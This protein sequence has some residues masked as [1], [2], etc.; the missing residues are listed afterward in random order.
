MRVSRARETSAS[1]LVATRRV[2]AVHRHYLY[3][4]NSN[5]QY[6]VQNWFLYEGSASIDVTAD[7]SSPTRRPARLRA[8][9]EAAPAGAARTL[10]RAA[11]SPS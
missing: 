2:L 8:A 10:T 5:N 11:R 3:Y 4:V 7:V 1:L 6:D 9:A